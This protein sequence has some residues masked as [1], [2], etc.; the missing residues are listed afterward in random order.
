[1]WS[2]QSACL[3]HVL[4]RAHR[5]IGGAIFA[6]AQN[7]YQNHEVWFKSKMDISSTDAGHYIFANTETFFTGF[8]LVRLSVHCLLLLLAQKKCASNSVHVFGLGVGD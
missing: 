8:R 4:T 2:A 3:A 6:A 5:D 7:I 1:M